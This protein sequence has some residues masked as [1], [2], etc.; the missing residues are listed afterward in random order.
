VPNQLGVWLYSAPGTV[1]GFSGASALERNVVSGNTY[2]GVAMGGNVSRS[3]V[4]GNYI[5]LD[6]SGSRPLGNGSSGVAIAYPDLSWE[7]AGIGGINPGEPNTI[8][9]NGGDGVT[10]LNTFLVGVVNNH[11]GTDASGTASHSPEGQSLGNR[12]N[13]VSIMGASYENVIGFMEPHGNI[14]GGNHGHGVSVS[15]QGR[16]NWIYGNFIGAHPSGMVMLSNGGDGV[17]IQASRTFVGNRF[18]GQRAAAN[19][20]A[21]NGGNGIKVAFGQGNA[22]RGNSVFAN[23]R[24][25]IDLGYGERAEDGQVTPNDSQDA[26]WDPEFGANRFQNFPVITSAQWL[27]EVDRLTITGTLDAAPDA[28]HRLEFFSG[29]QADP[30]GYGEGQTYL[31]SA[32][33][34]T[35][36]SGHVTFEVTLEVPYLNDTVITATAAGPAGDT[37]EFSQAFTAE[38]TPVDPSGFTSLYLTY[39]NPDGLYYGE[40]VTLTAYVAGGTV[41]ADRRPPPGRVSFHRLDPWTGEPV[42]LG[43]APLEPVVDT[44]AVARFTIQELP[45]GT[46]QV[47]ARYEG[48]GNYPG[49]EGGVTV[50]FQPD[51]TRGLVTAAPATVALGEPLLLTAFIEAEHSETPVTGLVAFF[52]YGPQGQQWLGTSELVDGTASLRVDTLPAGTYEVQATFEGEP[53]R[54]HSTAAFPATVQ[55]ERGVPAVIAGSPESP[56]KWG[57]PTLLAA[58]VLPPSDGAPAPTGEVTFMEGDTILGVAQL[59]E[60]GAEFV[61]TEPLAAGEHNV[62]ARYGGDAQYQPAESA[63]T[64]TVLP[65][66]TDL[67][68]VLDNTRP[69]FGQAVTVWADVHA[70]EFVPF[71]A[72]AS[73]SVILRENGVEIGRADVVEGRAQFQLA[74][75]AVGDHVIEADYSG[76]SAFAPASGGHFFMV[77]AAD[78]TTTLAASPEGAT[79]GQELTLTA[80]VI[81]AAPG[82]GVP[83]GRVEFFADGAFIGEAPLVQG[84]ATVTFTPAAAGTHQIGA[85]YLGSP[86]YREGFATPLLIDVSPAETTTVVSVAG[87]VTL[88]E[89]VALTAQVSATTPGQDTPQGSVTFRLGD[90]TVLGVAPLV[91]GVATFRYAATA[92]GQYAVEAAYEGSDRHA[93][94]SSAPPA[95]FTVNKAAAAVALTSSPSGVTVYGQAVTFT[96]AVSGVAGIVAGGTVEFY[97]GTTLLGTAPVTGGVASLPV[98]SLSAG[99]HEVVAAYQG[100]ANFT[101]A[102]SAPLGRVVSRA[103]TSV[104]LDASSASVPAD[105]AVTFTAHVSAVPTGAGVAAGTVTFF[106]GGVELGTAPLDGDGRA[107]FTTSFATVG[108]HWVTATYSGAENFA[109]SSPAGAGLVVTYP[110]TGGP[111]AVGQTAAYNFWNATKGQSLIRSFNGGL[112]ATALGHWLAE[113]FPRL[114]GPDATPGHNLAGRNN[115]QV[116]DY[117]RSQFN[118]SG[119]RLRAQVMALSLSVYATTDSLGGAT[120]G[121]YGFAVSRWGVM[122]ATWNVGARGAAFGVSD[123]SVLPVH[124]ILAAVN[125]RTVDGR[126]YNNDGVLQNQAYGVVDAINRAGRV[127]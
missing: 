26:A 96:A 82:G 4:R 64:L 104:S 40:T 25:G 62:V 36:A 87:S 100:D 58:Q 8:S 50:S 29:R 93:P 44:Q 11:I 109:P 22:L 103:A 10:L 77:V 106:E 112:S 79:P 70:R 57:R 31:G 115:A 37:S 20:I 47:I 2:E 1:V 98:S 90:G 49:S 60:S 86:G 42:L 19:V 7:S 28:T 124:R 91:D 63:F 123:Y 35:D 94:S 21:Y 65:L 16:D 69:V 27:R 67:F 66:E 9:A 52:A 81:P 108:E 101:A 92:A 51:T 117:Y 113:T 75:S 14:I 55:V 78:T 53:G 41:L 125:D 105:S 119:L 30:T 74:G 56:V 68:L 61:L 80:T 99:G 38:V 54:Y 12:R 88:G 39:D 43:F 122:I 76:D 121:A 118:A 89:E 84:V 33:V 32:E 97:E 71:G 73:G 107:S 127:S 17:N 6:A 15:G 95:T 24:L 5:G 45:P 111:V 102:T 13:G 126:L 3:A 59:R 85:R 34:R 18:E 46:H 114:F 110:S 23:A 48:G 83:E 116:A 120:G 72:R